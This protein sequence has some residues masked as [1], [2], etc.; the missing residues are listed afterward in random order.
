VPD[1]YFSEVLNWSLNFA[2]TFTYQKKIVP[3]FDW[4][5]KTKLRN[6]RNRFML[7]FA[8]E[9]LIQCFADI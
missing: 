9:C 4:V 8:L 5:A 3:T 2:P 6:I 1:L 7:D